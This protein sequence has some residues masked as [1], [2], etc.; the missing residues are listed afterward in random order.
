MQDIGICEELACID[1]VNIPEV[2]LTFRN[3]E[4]LFG[5]DQDLA[6]ALLD[7]KDMTCF[8]VERDT[9]LNGLDHSCAKEIEVCID[10]SFLLHLILWCFRQLLAISLP[11]S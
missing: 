1:N 10:A 2:D 6:R 3:F 5:C 7:D 4:E 8:S 9:S 11:K